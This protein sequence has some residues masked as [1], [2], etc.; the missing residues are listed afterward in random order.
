[1]TSAIQYNR[2]KMIMS[3]CRL[4]SN[5]VNSYSARSSHIVPYPMVDNVKD[6]LSVRDLTRTFLSQL[7]KLTHIKRFPQKTE[8]INRKNIIAYTNSERQISFS[9]LVLENFSPFEPII[10]L[11]DHPITFCV[12]DTVSEIVDNN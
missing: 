5:A 8:K 7:G 12:V 10:G 3:T 2:I 1:M 4:K 11:Q 6:K 9:V